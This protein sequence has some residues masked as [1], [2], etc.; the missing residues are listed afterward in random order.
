MKRRYTSRQA[1]EKIRRWVNEETDSNTDSSCENDIV[2]SECQPDVKNPDVD[3]GSE[4]QD[5]IAES[6]SADESSND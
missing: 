6:N 3:S 5:Y 1:I 4:T 2:D